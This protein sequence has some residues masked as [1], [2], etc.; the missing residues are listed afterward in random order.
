MNIPRP[1]LNLNW[2]TTRAFRASICTLAVGLIATAAHHTTTGNLGPTA[3]ATAALGLLLVYV[4]HCP[5]VTTD[6]E[7]DHPAT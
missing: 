5:T 1:N 6:D 2:D 7:P 4:G 3:A